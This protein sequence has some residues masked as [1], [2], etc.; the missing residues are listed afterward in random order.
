MITDYNIEYTRMET[1]VSVNADSETTH[2][3]SG[4]IPNVMYSIRVAAE[5]ING[6]GAFSD[7]MVGTSGEDSEFN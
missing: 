4:L 1:N 6:T 7:P 2:K 3:I 5:N